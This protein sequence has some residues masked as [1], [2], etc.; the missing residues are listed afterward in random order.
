MHLWLRHH[1]LLLVLILFTSCAG[2]IKLISK[3][4]K[5]REVDYGYR[6]LE[7]SALPEGSWHHDFLVRNSG[8]EMVAEVL[9]SDD[10]TLSFIVNSGVKTNQQLACT[11][12]RARGRELILEELVAKIH[13]PLKDE[14][15]SY[16]IEKKGTPLLNTQLAKVL[17]KE[18]IVGEYWEKRSY[19]SK[20]EKGDK[21]KLYECLLL[22]KVEKEKLAPAVYA[23]REIIKTDYLHV[24]T[25]SNDVLRV[26]LP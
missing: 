6:I 16:L 11:L 26:K 25:I 5:K 20:N 7:A 13:E 4:D 12:A 1:A 2:G 8:R 15:W 3:N 24:L 17:S 19:P 10:Q 22:I 21:D 14:P 18:S 9:N 23:I